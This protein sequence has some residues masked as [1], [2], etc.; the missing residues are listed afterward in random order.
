MKYGCLCVFW[1]L[2]DPRMVGELA[3]DVSSSTPIAWSKEV[4][5]GQLL[6]EGYRIHWYRRVIFA[7]DL[8][9]PPER[10][11]WQIQAG[12]CSLLHPKK[13]RHLMGPH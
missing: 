1:A 7:S 8:N 9:F 10:A 6:A 11:S 4:V 12:H 2:F 3:S 13:R 5:W